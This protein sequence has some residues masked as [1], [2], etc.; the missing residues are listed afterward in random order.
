MN[1]S[2]H[3]PTP[4][5][6]ASSHAHSLE[7]WFSS[8][9]AETPRPRMFGFCVYGCNAAT[10][11]SSRPIRDHRLAPPRRSSP[12]PPNSGS[13]SELKAIEQ[14]IAAL[15]AGNSKGDAKNFAASVTDGFVAI[16]AIGGIASKQDRMTQLAKR[17]DAGDPPV[18]AASTRIY[19][20]VA[21]TIRLIKPAGG[22]PLIQMIIH[23]KQ[24]GRWLRAATIATA[25]NPLVLLRLLSPV[26][27]P[28]TPLALA[29]PW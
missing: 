23:A 19:G 17:P 25:R 5:Q 28:P 24:S 7:V 6:R 13:A 29:A 11:G 22:Q 18:D 26:A 9:H 14:A 15:A 21:V 2:P 12:M 4:A 27:V 20:D 10:D 8:A 1:F 16:N 3:P